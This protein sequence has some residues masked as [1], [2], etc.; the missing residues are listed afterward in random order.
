MVESTIIYYQCMFQE[1]NDLATNCIPC[2]D[3]ET[4]TWFSCT[5][6]CCYIN[7]NNVLL[8]ALLTSRAI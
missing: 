1:S 8:F 7:I 3:D 6:C 4:C 2:S 5:T